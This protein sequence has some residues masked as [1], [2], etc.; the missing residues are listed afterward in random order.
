MPFRKKNDTAHYI[1]YGKNSITLQAS[2]KMKSCEKAQRCSLPAASVK[3]AF[4]KISTRYK[5]YRLFGTKT[6]FHL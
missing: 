4:N 3:H 2:N 6:K 1:W 5:A